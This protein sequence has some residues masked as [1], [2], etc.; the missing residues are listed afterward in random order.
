MDSTA[1]VQTLEKAICISHSLNI[2]GEDM[3]PITIPKA[4]GK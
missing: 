1:R 2:F 4:P 3:H